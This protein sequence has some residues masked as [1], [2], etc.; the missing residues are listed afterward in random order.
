MDRD[1][2]PS[3]RRIAR[4]RLAK[5][6]LRAAPKPLAEPVVHKVVF[7]G[8]AES[9]PELLDRM[10]QASAERA[11]IAEK[12]PAAGSGGAGSGGFTELLRTLGS[13]SAPPPP[14]P[15]AREAPAPARPAQPSGFTSLLQTLNAPEAA[16]PP[17][18]PV[19]EQPR[20]APA[21][22]G[23]GGFTELLRTTAGADAGSGAAGL[24]APGPAEAPFFAGAAGAV[25]AA[26]EG[27]PGA[28]TQLFGTFG[29]EASA[30]V[31]AASERGPAGASAAKA[32]SFTRMLSLEPQPP[33]REPTFQEERKP[34]P[35]S[36]NYGITPGMPAQA[37]P[38]RDPFAPPPAE[39]KPVE[40]TPPGS[41]AG[42]TRLIQML[43]EPS[44]PPAAPVEAPR[45]S[46]PQGKEPGAW[47][48]TFASLST[49]GEPAPVA[50]APAWA[51]PPPPAA[52]A[53]PAR[54]AQFSA[55][56]NEPVV[57]PAAA[58]GPSEF[59]RI[60]DASRMRE[61]AMRGGAGAA[62]LPQAPLPPAPLPRLPRRFPHPRCP[63][64]RSQPRRRWA[65]CRRW[66][67]CL[68]PAFTLP[69]CRSRL[70]IQ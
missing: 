21:A 24:P 66:G 16:A 26:A 29:S 55:S 17:V 35:G 20:P 8:G 22:S 59:T 32:D 45:V 70:L 63:V 11:P 48:Q 18:R 46:P 30:P 15:P 41:G 28:F 12:V 51:S 54:E 6:L 60:L 34:L 49:P 14:P 65:G 58:S 36:V 62:N 61:M 64:I 27:K 37:A 57:H 4:R 50:K 42:I 7:G 44:R 3:S 9:S 1:W 47:T 67:R 31:P 53:P 56:L 38:V 23:S 52:T 43:D 40:S 69:R 39:A 25:P 2:S 13:D 68:S 10:R 5:P 19:P 33:A